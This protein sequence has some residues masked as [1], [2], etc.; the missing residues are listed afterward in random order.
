LHDIDLGMARQQSERPPQQAF[1]A[2]APELFRHAAAG[3]GPAPGRYHYRRYLDH[4]ATP[5][6][7]ALTRSA[8][9][10]SFLQ[11]S[12]CARCKIV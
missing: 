7:H 8:G 10:H 12:T 2:H 3:A 5:F 1:A 11:C 4:A 6:H 9:G